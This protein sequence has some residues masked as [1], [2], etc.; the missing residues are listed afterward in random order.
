MSWFNT[1]TFGAVLLA[2]LLAG[3]GVY[4]AEHPQLKR[5]SA[6]NDATRIEK[7]N[8][9]SDYEKMLKASQVK[10][11]ELRRLQF[12]RQEVVQL[13]DEVSKLQKSLEEFREKSVKV[14][15]PTNAAP[16][17]QPVPMKLFTPGVY[18]S[19]AELAFGG[20]RTPEAGIQSMTYAMMK[21]N[22]EMVTNGM[23]IDLLENLTQD[24]SF[25][26]E[27]EEQQLL[28]APLF[29]GLQIFA[30]KTVDDDN[31]ELKIKMES[32]PAAGGEDTP[33]GLLIQR[34]TRVG[35][36]WK[37]TGSAFPYDPSWEE[38]GKI[39]TFVP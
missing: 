26:K 36:Q 2:A 32:D 4:L 39:R 25:K 28:L 38:D 24:P 34:L 15:A 21:G 11:R 18:I 23:A 9:K 14:A 35:Q 22:Y 37:I 3:L 8:A 5:L 33:N 13:R 20:Y 27:F 17:Q 19:K 12:S 31:V 16:A 1:K 29:K 30:K 10:D 6:E 7:Q